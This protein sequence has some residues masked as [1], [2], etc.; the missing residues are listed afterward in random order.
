M[1]ALQAI[2]VE[3]G[4]FPATLFQRLTA[5]EIGTTESRT[6]ASYGLVGSETMRDAANRAWSYLTGAWQ[7]WRKAQAAAPGGH[8]GTAAALA[9]DKWL[10]VL[11][12]EL[13]YGRLPAKTGGIQVG[14]AE[15][16]PIS[17]LWQHVPIHL[18][19]PGVDLDRRNPG[20]AGA[21]RAPQ[22][23][24]QDLLNRSDDHLWAI[25]SNGR[26]L[27][28]LRDSTALAGSAFVEFDLEAIFDG[29]LFAE[30]LL[31]WQTCHASRLDLRPVKDG[32]PTPAD[33]WLELWRADSVRAG[34]RALERLRVG[35][36]NALQHLGT[37]FLRHPDNRELIEALRTGKLTREDFHRH[38]L[39]L[40]YRLLFLFVTEDRNL[41]LAPGGDPVA[42]ARYQ[43][44]LS[45][46]RVR[47][48]ARQRHGS[49]AYADLWRGQRLVLAAL[50]SD[51]EPAL[52]LLALGGLFD[53]EEGQGEPLLAA[54][55]D[56]EAFLEA[57]R[58]LAWMVDNRSRVQPVDY[59]NL[60]AEELGGVY[61]SLLELVPQVSVD[62]HTFTFERLSGN[63]RKT[64]GSYYTPPALVSALLDSALDPV[65]DD[66]VRGTRDADEAERALLGLRVCDPAC[67]SGHFLVAAARRIAR[68][69]AAV[70][71]GEEEPTPDA[72][73]HALRDVVGRCVYGVDI[74]PM[75]AEL[76]KVSLWLEAMEPGKALGFL[77]ARIRVGNSL[78]GATPSLLQAGVPDDAFKTLGGDDT[79]YA[80][81]IKKSNRLERG[82]GSGRLGFSGQD[83]FDLDFGGGVVHDLAEGRTE[84]FIVHDDAAAV[85]EQA[86]R[87]RRYATSPDYLQ[88]KVHADA[89][90]AAFVWPLRPSAITR[91]SSEREAVVIPP[92]SAVVRQFET[93]P[94][95]MSLAATREQIE[96]IA[97]EYR[98]FHWHLEF[99]EIFDRPGGLAGEAGWTG[100]FD[101]MLGNPPWE[102]VKLQEQEFFAAR[103][104]EIAKA[105][106]AAARKR[107]IFRLADS[108]SEAE[109]ALYREYTAALRRAEGE[110]ALLRTSGS[111]PLAGRGDVN[112][113]AVFTEL[114]RTLTGP[115]GQAGIIV[116]TGIATDATTQHFFRDLVETK[117]IAALYDF[118]NG[119]IFEAVDT[120][121]KFCLLTMTGRD[122]AADAASFAF[123]LHDARDI[124]SREFALTPEEITLLNPNTGTL[125]IFR[126]RRD[127]EITLGI[128]RRVPVL[129]DEKK[130]A[131][132]DPDGNPWGVKFM[133]MF[134]MSN[135][136]H[137]FRT[138]EQL[139]ADGWILDGN[140]FVRP[141]S[142]SGKPGEERS[143]DRYL[144]LYEA[145]MVAAYDHRSADVV[146][147]A[148]AT[149]RQNQ[150]RYLSNAEHE[151]PW[152]F[153]QPGSWVA[154]DNVVSSNRASWLSFLRITSPT[155][156]R[157][158]IASIIPS[159]AVGDSLFIMDAV[160]QERE[161]LLLAQIN[162]FALDFVARQKIAGL[163]ANF[164]YVK[165][166]PVLSPK[167]FD[168][169]CRWGGG[170]DLRTWILSRV[171]N[172]QYTS[173]DLDEFVKIL[174]RNDDVRRWNAGWRSIVLA[175]L[176]AAL[177][178]CYGVSRDDIDFIMET[179]P[180]VRRKDEAE[181]GEYRT[182]R[183]ILEVFDSMQAAMDTGTEYEKILGPPPGQGPRHTAIE[184]PEDGVDAL[185]EGK[186]DAAIG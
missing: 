92:T 137:L 36:E 134:H 145:K 22:A 25:L 72:V 100:G 4:I 111:Y 77:D 88:R 104:P 2:R 7:D 125:P 123:F 54:E 170:E 69:L 34:S 129:I 110:S 73:R 90:S 127:A 171:I 87:W 142:E 150:P 63:E 13:D 112:T 105:P 159:C 143:R 51:G 99:P 49:P 98:F 146:R 168:S 133:T 76:A 130:V 180:I 152:R 153:A 23:M 169:V 181:H 109:R 164:F 19:G 167:I 163:N 179:F 44:Y 17:H 67:G 147:S 158:F 93:D 83:A 115:R 14:D 52:G 101:A 122:R 128:Y 75:A 108:D 185:R 119:S 177:F 48:Q 89:W 64:T 149:K 154:E 74:N 29:E 5:G 56:N 78:L 84:F 113:Y 95:S 121:F 166:F 136:S 175:E 148:T 86:R 35:V 156:H 165:Q 114:F 6:A 20:V 47:R 82:E 183:L 50:G 97:D 42:A 59:R 8:E 46:Q 138:R 178:H 18:L 61:E 65:I 131:A 141:E 41:L 9:R 79:K 53:A 103:D 81:Q 66:A 37:G 12:R 162:S 62:D 151:D 57:V 10:L 118:E 116:P 161:C 43:D 85:R 102:R 40:V 11:L 33:C 30:F 155:N 135:D 1:S 24:V 91:A 32:E 3:G 45:T 106:N 16:F 184:H 140:V 58:D 172:L 39:R 15:P 174:G 94:D 80:A 96:K 38:L 139:E 55:L 160:S 186:H 157:T 31:L 182:K 27:R 144:P 120:R 124:E 71:S 176:D 26:R 107:L 117:T 132:G 60:G 70:R 28:L 126:T 173:H 68:R 21:S